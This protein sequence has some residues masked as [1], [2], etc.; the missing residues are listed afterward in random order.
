MTIAAV[1]LVLPTVLYSTFPK[2]IDISHKILLFS[3]ATAIVLL[4][5]Y[6]VYLYFQMGTHREV[7]ISEDQDIGLSNAISGGDA[8]RSEHRPQ[9][10]AQNEE[11]YTTAP[12]QQHQDESQTISAAEI[13][14]AVAVLLFCGAAIG[15]CTYNMMTNID[16]TAELAYTTKTF[17]ATIILPIV[18]NAPEL[19][20]VYWAARDRRINFAIAVIV[21]SILQIALFVLPILV[22]VGWCINRHMRLYYET[23]QTCV[24]FLAFLIVNQILQDGRYTYL[25]GAMLITM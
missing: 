19:S 3:R 20:S 15:I 18:S 8:Q 22:V 23:S 21:G 2:R 6:V 16:Q 4:L 10:G 5:V 13:C 11:G 12:V 25:N 1:V 14:K 24:L 9:E 7:F 17:I